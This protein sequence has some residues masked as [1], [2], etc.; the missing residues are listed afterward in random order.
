MN[1]IWYWLEPL[2]VV[3]LAILSFVFMLVFAILPV[4]FIKHIPITTNNILILAGCMII[5]F[6]LIIVRLIR[7]FE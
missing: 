7:N 1:K 6:L 4:Y 3:V 2:I 5:D